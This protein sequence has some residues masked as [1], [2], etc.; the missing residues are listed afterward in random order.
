VSNRLIDVVAR[1]QF[2]VGELLALKA[3]ERFA[4]IS[5][6]LSSS[7]MVEA[8]AGAAAAIGAEYT[9]MMQPTR[10]PAQKNK[11]SPMVVAALEHADVMVGITASG[12]APTYSKVVKRLLDEKRLRVMSMVMRD[13][14]IFT[15]GGAL[16]DYRA[17]LRHGNRL[18][19]IW[20]R[21]RFMHITSPA[22]TDI[23]APIAADDVIV[24]CGYA[25]Q[26]GMEAAFSDGEVSSRPLEGMAEG[27]VVADG[28]M[29]VLGTLAAPITLMVRQGRVV[30]VAGASS[31][32]LELEEIVRRIP[33]ADNI[34]EFG[35]GL[36]PACRRNGRFEEEKKALGNVHIA[37]GDNVFYGGQTESPVHMDMVIYQ[38]TVRLDDLILVEAGRVTI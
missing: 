11:L 23:R 17:L 8:L 1:A 34:A 26:P 14:E 28:P 27:V 6:P 38:P 9:V 21:G 30:S 13:N 35:I 2:I 29:A 36:N 7:E 24:E 25:D 31:Q 33:N 20:S 5:D 15:R 22:G 37:L 16:A 3:T 32:A 18:R 19:D 10:Q 12:G 4:V